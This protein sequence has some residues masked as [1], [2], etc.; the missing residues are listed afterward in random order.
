MRRL[1]FFLQG[2]SRVGNKAI[3]SLFLLLRLCIIFHFSMV[4]EKNAFVS[5]WPVPVQIAV[6]IFPLLLTRSP[7]INRGEYFAEAFLRVHITLKYLR[8]FK[9]YREV[10]FIFR[11]IIHRP[12]TVMTLPRYR[13]WPA[14]SFSSNSRVRTV[15]SIS[16]SAFSMITL[17]SVF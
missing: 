11:Y 7:A 6:R 8:V 13:T 3:L 15:A 2:P 4:L 1:S 5:T 10:L 17:T 14:S 12:D 16:T 9:V